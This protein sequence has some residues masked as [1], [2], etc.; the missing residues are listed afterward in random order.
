MTIVL[1]PQ[2]NDCQRT[3]YSQ[4]MSVQSKR[5][6]TSSGTMA[7]DCLLSKHESG[8]WEKAD[9]KVGRKQRKQDTPFHFKCIVQDNK[10]M[11]RKKTNFKRANVASHQ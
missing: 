3:D 9:P 6:I 2:H 4:M 10:R 8:R 5:E 7:S 11:G 1:R